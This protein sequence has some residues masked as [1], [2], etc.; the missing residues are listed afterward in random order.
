MLSYSW[1]TRAKSIVRM[2]V[3]HAMGLAKF[4]SLYK[5]LLVL[6]RR[7][8]GGKSR[9]SDTFFAG[10]IGGFLVFGERTAIN[11]QVHIPSPAFPFALQC[12]HISAPGRSC[13]TSSPVSSPPSS[14]GTAP[15]RARAAR[16]HPRPAAPH[17]PSSPTRASSPSSPP[18]RGARS[19]GS[20]TT[21]ARRSSRACGAR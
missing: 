9:N 15:L 14:R 2:T 4:V 6:Q 1:T 18:S 11:E 17:G 5:A 19:C 10:L 20:S 16:R 8:N 13:S 12:T 7:L 21:E 3:Q